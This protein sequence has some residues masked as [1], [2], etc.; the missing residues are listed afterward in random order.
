MEREQHR[1][2]TDLGVERT[3]SVESPLVGSEDE[4]SAKREDETCSQ[5]SSSLR[6]EI[7]NRLLLELT[8][9][10]EVSLQPGGWKDRDVEEEGC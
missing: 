4:I 8:D 3:W 5:F 2:D 1:R 10:K 9:S 6:R 7:S